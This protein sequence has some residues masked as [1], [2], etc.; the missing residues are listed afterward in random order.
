[1]KK[2]KESEWFNAILIAAGLISCSFGY[3]LFLVPNEIAAGGFTGISQL[4]HTGTGLPIGGVMLALNIPLF[5]ISMKSLGIRF[6][7]RSLIA[8]IVFSILLDSLQ[9]PVFVND[10]WLA[11]VYGGLTCGL[12]FGLI[13]RG[14][15]TTGGSD[16]LASVI[17]RF[18]PRIRIS[19][20]L[21]AVDASVILA[22]AFVYDAMAAMYAL[23]CILI[24]N[25]VVDFVLEGPNSSHSYFIISDK[26][27]EIAERILR[28]V[29]RGVTALEGMGMYS[30][31]QKRVLFCVVSRMESVSL[32][33]IVFSTDP[34]AFVVA[35][36]AHDTY[37]EGFKHLEER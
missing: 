23:I 36:K 3:N 28:E 26:S 25:I 34:R 19:V 18:I 7:I 4:I 13:M 21:F 10:K 30:K 8:T 20:A 14:S 12:G 35:N 33:R 11:T 37:G 27:D 22:S 32:R 6:G 15:A 29:D 1:M 2:F 5:F 31:T 17:H 24:C 16:M 9:L